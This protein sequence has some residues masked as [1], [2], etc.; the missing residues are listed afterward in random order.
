MGRP[1]RCAKILLGLAFTLANGCAPSGTGVATPTGPTPDSG[2]GLEALFEARADSARMRFTEADV[3]FVTGMIGH[4]AQALEMASLAPTHGA[5]PAVRTLAARIING[6]RDEIASME[7]WLRDRGQ[8]VP[9]ISP[10]VASN[11]VAI[12]DHAMHMPGMLTPEQMEELENAHGNE[13]DRLFLSL[14]IQHH[15]GAVTVVQELFAID[16][17]V[18]DE[19]LFKLASDMHVDQATEIARMEQMLATIP[20]IDRTP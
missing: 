13:F 7:Q 9:E 17:A 8:P 3:R 20:T 6:Q 16:G 2:N 1:P 18:Q 10:A 12:P 14:M 5:A 4:H 19:E 11:E 15:Q